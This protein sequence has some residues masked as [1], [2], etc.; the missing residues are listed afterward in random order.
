MVTFL[1]VHV[2]MTTPLYLG[3]C[4]TCYQGKDEETKEEEGP[5]LQEIMIFLK[6]EFDWNVH[7]D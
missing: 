1:V 5:T 2:T 7:F 6:C 4:W 3:I